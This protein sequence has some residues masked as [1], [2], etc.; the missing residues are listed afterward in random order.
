MGRAMPPRRFA[1]SAAGSGS[2]L[3]LQ[4]V[5]RLVKEGRT[6]QALELFK[7]SASRDPAV[8]RAKARAQKAGKLVGGALETYDELTLIEPRAVDVVRAPSV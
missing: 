2:G 1:S 6:A 8:L 3:D 7:G 4:E 5:E